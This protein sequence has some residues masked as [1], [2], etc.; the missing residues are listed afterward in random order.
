M[1]RLHR[2][3]QGARFAR[4]DPLSGVAW[5]SVGSPRFHEVKAGEGD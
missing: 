4:C 3:R 5:P 2:K 1:Q